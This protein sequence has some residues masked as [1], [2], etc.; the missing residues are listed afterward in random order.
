MPKPL[1]TTKFYIPTPRQEIVPRLRLVEMLNRGLDGK[2]TLISAPAG[3]GKTTLLSECV[4]QCDRKVAWLSLDEGDND[5]KRFLSYLI[6]ALGNI[7][8]GIG[9]ELLIAL[10]ATLTP[11]TESILTKL[12][13]DLAAVSQPITLVLDDYHVIVEPEIQEMML[14]VLEN[15]PIQMHI[16]ISSRSDPPWPL[17]RFRVRGD[18][19][20][21][22]GGL[23]HAR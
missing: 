16:V 5:S 20:A 8:S 9:D 17:A 2:L 23:L 3:F 22:Q 18:L 21:P 7:V 10:D 11:D 12:V 19:G 14:F 1:L 4:R 15:Q 6:T 13:N